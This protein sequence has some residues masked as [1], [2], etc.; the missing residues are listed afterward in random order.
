[1]KGNNNIDY[2]LNHFKRDE[3][4]WNDVL[5]H[6]YNKNINDDVSLFEV[7]ASNPKRLVKFETFLIKHG[8]L[9]KNIIEQKSKRFVENINRMLSTAKEKEENRKRSQVEAN[10]NKE[11]E[12]INQCTFAPKVNKRQHNKDVTSNHNYNPNSKSSNITVY[13]RNVLWSNNL[14]GKKASQRQTKELTNLECSFFPNVN[15]NSRL[16]NV[17]NNKI[18]VESY[19][20]NNLFYLKTQALNKKKREISVNYSHSQSSEKRT[21]TPKSFSIKNL[22]ESINALRYE[23][24]NYNEEDDS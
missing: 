8:Q 4:F 24:R 1:M 20:Y 17:F 3:D 2:Q 21:K 16:D 22:N 7:K 14:K 5:A 18:Q 13:E 11:L 9:P 12:E 19:P 23:L 6:C 10:R 15:D